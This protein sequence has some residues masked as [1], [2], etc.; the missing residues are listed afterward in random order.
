M[1]DYANLMKERETINEQL[2]GIIGIINRSKEGTIEQRIEKVLGKDKNAMEKLHTI[3]LYIH[4]L[5]HDIESTKR[6]NKYLRH[7]L[8]D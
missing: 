8:D 3:R 1:K 7:M 6:E 2:Q 5:L 4:S